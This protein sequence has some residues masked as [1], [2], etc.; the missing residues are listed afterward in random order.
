MRAKRHA[1]GEEPEIDLTP[2]L[3]VVFI[4]LIFFIVTASFIKEAGIDVSR[5]DAVT[6]VVQ[7]RANIVVAVTE[8]GEVWINRRQIDR[9]AIRANIERLHA[10]NP[11]GAV[12]ITADEKADVGLMVEVMDQA[13]QAGVYNVS[14]AADQK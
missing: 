4:M 1:G 7:E 2:M 8:S 14:I 6:A 13:R 11:Q 9:R 10:E 3:D 12:V 5:P